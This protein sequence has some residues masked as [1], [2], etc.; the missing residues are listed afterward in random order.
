MATV[1]S[2]KAHSKGKASAIGVTIR[3]RKGKHADA[4]VLD[5]VDRGQRTREHLGLY[6]TGDRDKDRETMLLA[7]QI[8]AKR[9]RERAMRRSGFEE[10]QLR[11]DEDFLL[12]YDDLMKDHGKPWRNVRAHL[13]RFCTVRPR[14]GD[15]GETWIDGFRRHLEKQGLRTNSI[16]TYMDVLKT[17][18][19]VA[20]RRK[21][22]A[23]NP[24]VYTRSTKRV[25][26]NREFL[27][28]EELRLL[29]ASN[30]EHDMVKR[31][32]LFACLTGLRISDLKQLRWSNILDTEI[33]IVQK[34][35]GDHITIPLSEQARQI[36]PEKGTAK[37]GDLIFAYPS[38]DDVYND[39][40]LKW[41]RSVGITKH[42]TSHVARHTFATLLVT[43]GTDLYAV[44]HLLGH[45]DLR[46]TQI[47]AKLVDQRKVDAIKSLPTL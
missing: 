41:M 43:Q 33:R 40:L 42:V 29:W 38:R 2:K 13:T 27:T 28:L 8:K 15:I 34:K 14:F 19:N 26:T 4:L 1:T 12:F 30:A 24:F 36:L 6:L 9:L 47:Y 5:V 45:R 17:S 32:F 23:V 39:R 31:S 46:V 18:F 10:M 16:A 22:I 20:V 44:Q 7:E 25:R 21:I 3:I 37:S 35:T 11:L